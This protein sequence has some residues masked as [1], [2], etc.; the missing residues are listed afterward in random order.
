MGNCCSNSKDVRVLM[1]GLDAAGKTS[2]LQKL[3]KGNS[4]STKPTVGFN[5]ETVLYKK[6]KFTIWDVGGQDKIRTLWRHYYENVQAILFVVDSSDQER[7]QEAKNELQ[8]MLLEEELK[9]SALVVFA[10]KQDLPNTITSDN[11]ISKFDLEKQTNRKWACL[12]TCAIS[13]DGLYEGLTWIK[14][15]LFLK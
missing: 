2:I 9:N 11:L 7:L 1:V 10:N 6:V 5:V 3:S 13:G 4:G 12:P 14:D 8:K 15:A